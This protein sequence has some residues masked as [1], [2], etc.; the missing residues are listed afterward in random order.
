MKLNTEQRETLTELMNAETD[1]GGSHLDA[2]RLAHVQ[3]TPHRR[4]VFLD[5]A[6]LHFSRALVLA[7][8]L[9]ED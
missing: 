2:S 1:R 9:K 6:Q 8:L 3:E 7:E 5:T 4:E